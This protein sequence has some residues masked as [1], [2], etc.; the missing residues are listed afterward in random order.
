MCPSLAKSRLQ[1]KAKKLCPGW[2]STEV[3]KKQGPKN[4]TSTTKQQLLKQNS[5]PHKEAS[6]QGE[7]QVCRVVGMLLLCSRALGGAVGIRAGGLRVRPLVARARAPRASVAL[8]SS[9]GLT[10]DER[11]VAEEPETVRTSLRRRQASEEVLGAV[12]RIGE[13]TRERAALVEVGNA[14]RA[15]RKALSPKIGALLKAGD[16]GA[17]ESLKAE[18][19]A[20]SEE[21]AAADAKMEVIEAER[22]A[23]FATLP[24]LL[25]ARTPNGADEQDNQC[26]FEWGTEGP[27]PMDRV[28]HDEA[29]TKLGGLDVEAAAKLAGS[30]FAVLR[31]PIARMERAIANFF[32]DMH[33]EEHGYREVNVPFL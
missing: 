19:A 13:L 15:Q 4:K 2:K 7:M 6:T 25:D 8:E 29:A 32:L 30:R 23:L 16:D 11:L 28:W 17:V 33:T 22:G 1:K 21:A 31:G 5:D 12:D 18:V 27:L 9:A 26:V 3:K 14:A 20:A 10:L 24:N